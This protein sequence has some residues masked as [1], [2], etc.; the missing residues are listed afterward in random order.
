MKAFELKTEYLVNPLGLATRSPRLY[1]K[2]ED[3]VKQTAYELEYTVNDKPFPS[4][5][6][7]TSSTTHISF[8]QTL[9]SRDRVLW[10]V[11]LRDENGVWGEYS[12]TASFEM[13]LLDPADFSAEWISGDYCVNKRKRYPVDCFRKTFE[14]E[15]V[16]RARLYATACGLFEAKI[17]GNRVGDFV[18]APG[19]TDYLKRVRLLT[20]DVTPLLKNGENEITAELADGWY[21]GSCGAWGLRNQYGSR[22]KLLMQLELFFADG[23]SKTV[24]TD[25]SW[26]WSNDGSRRFADNKDG[27]RVDARMNPTYSGHAVP[28]SHSVFPTPT[29]NVYLVEK[30]RFKPTLIKT[31]S[32]KTV[33]DFGKNIA[34]YIAFSLSAKAGE[35]IFL[36]FGEMFDKNGEFTQINIQCANKK[37]TRVTPL[38]QVEYICRDGK[39]DYKTKFAIFG[40]Q[41]VLIETDIPFSADDFEAVAVYSDMKPTAEFSCSN[42]LVNRFVAC[43]LLSA[44]NNHADV[45]TDC[46]TRER[47]GWTGDAQIFADT[48]SYFFEYAPFARK[49]ILDMLDGQRRNGKFRQITPRGGIDRYMNAMDG[50]AGWSDAGVLIPYRIWKRYG[51]ESVI[52]DNYAAMKKYVDYKIKTLGRFYP[53]ARPTGIDRRQ[54]KNISNYGQ[55]YGE[56]AEPAD[57]HPIVWQDFVSPHPEETTAYIAYVCRLMSEIAEVLEKSDDSKRFA[58]IADR[59]K[60]G[61]TALRKTEKFTLDTSRQASLVRPIYFDLLAPEQTEFAKKRL[62]KA[63]DEYGWRLGTGFLSTP[64]ILYVLQDISPEYAYRLLENEQMPGWL[65]MPKMG[66]T[67]VWEAWEGTETENGGI[68]SLDHYSKGAVCEWIF[69]RMCGI[70][71]SGENRFEITPCVGGSITFASFAYDSLYGKVSCAWKRDGGKVTFEVCVPPNTSARFCACGIDRELSVGVNVIESEIC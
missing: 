62:V 40:F 63:L 58:A 57:V 67:T 59:V 48:A 45:P 6:V 18:L 14:A 22:T 24:M 46:P 43:T 68:A 31:P 35:K 41:Y 23:S 42:D 69:S 36:R 54:K 71:V 30:E 37:R 61:Y 4:V 25:G 2:C 66:A 70:N 21:R 60:L 19:H 44:K 53:T 55:S 65:F 51:D 56:W 38:Q 33:L 13:S 50:S 49:Y 9:A 11:R 29:D 52:R 34:G 17:N 16:V 5:T 28:T 1:W 64:L 47:H 32:G 7:K 8:P 27:E 10:R 3:G 12:D 39:N 26:Q 20:F 15:N